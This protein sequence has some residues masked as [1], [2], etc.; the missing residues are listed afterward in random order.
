MEA[1]A[2]KCGYLVIWKGVIKRRQHKIYWKVLTPIQDK[3]VKYLDK[4]NKANM[5]GKEQT[6]EVEKSLD[7]EVMKIDKFK[8][9][10]TYKSWILQYMLLQRLMWQ[11]T[12]Y[13]I[14]ASKVKEMQRKFKKVLM[15]WLGIP[16]NLWISCMYSKS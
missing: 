1:K 3:P 8:L 7:A 10:G 16:N 15:K 13:N 6:A 4:E 12:I 9:L 5:S 11:L 14:P 2:E